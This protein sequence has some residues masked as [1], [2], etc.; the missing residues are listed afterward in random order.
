MA[1]LEIVARVERKAVGSTVDLR[2][3]QE[4]LQAAVL[5]VRLCV[6]RLAVGTCTDRYV[7]SAIYTSN[8]RVGWRC[9]ESDGGGHGYVAMQKCCVIS[10]DSSAETY[11]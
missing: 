9:S 3:F 6:E 4:S 8:G 10:T 5:A 2:L 11:S 1:K 7:Y